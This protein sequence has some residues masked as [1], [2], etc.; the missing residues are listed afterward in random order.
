MNAK[1]LRNWIF[2]LHRYLGLAIALVVIIVGITGSLLVFRSEISHSALQQQI[3]AIVPQGE[4]LS[5][6]TILDAVKPTYANQPDAKLQ[7]LYLSP[8]PDEPANVAY[9]TQA[10]DW[11]DNY[12]NP[13][14]GT[15]LGNTLKPDAAQHSIDVIYKLHYALLAGDIG[16]K[17]LA[18]WVC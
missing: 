7:A 12:V 13:Y 8:K 14:T 17:W 18:L 11:I 10:K 6:E 1:I 3:G 2:A 16:L 4:P 15:V 5:V 9:S